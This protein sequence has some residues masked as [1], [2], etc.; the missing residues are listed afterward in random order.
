MS[1]RHYRMRKECGPIRGDG[2]L[3]GDCL[4]IVD[5]FEPWRGYR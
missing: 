5:Q 1:F 3:H 2:A 4:A